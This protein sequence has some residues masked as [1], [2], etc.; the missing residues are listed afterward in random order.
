MRFTQAYQELTR[1]P[2]PRVESIPI[3]EV[4]H[5]LEILGK[6]QLE[7]K[8]IAFQIAVT[9]DLQHIKGDINL[10][11]QVFLNLLTNSIEALHGREDPII[12]IHFSSTEEGK[13]MIRFTDNGAGMTEDVREQIFVPFYTTRK[14]GSGIGL[15]LCKQIIR[16]HGGMIGVESVK[17]QGTSFTIIL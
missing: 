6:A 17:D 10:L 13:T 5:R 9:D 16:L 1:I 11:D 7:D 12:G 15:S 3:G 4:M 2:Q 8:D 14:K